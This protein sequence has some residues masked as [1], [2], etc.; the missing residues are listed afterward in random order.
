[1]KWEKSMG[2]WEKFMGNEL[3]QNIEK[4]EVRGGSWRRGKVIGMEGRCKRRPRT[5]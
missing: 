5:E 2:S 4:A 1:L 3:F